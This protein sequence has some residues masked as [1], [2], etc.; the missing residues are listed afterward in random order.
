M[1]KCNIGLLS[2]TMA[3]ALFSTT[4]YATDIQVSVNETGSSCV[5][6]YLF[7]VEFEHAEKPGSPM[8]RIA[9]EAARF[10]KPNALRLDPSR[11]LES[12][13]ID[14]RDVTDKRKFMAY[15]KAIPEDHW[16]DFDL[17]TAET[18]QAEWFDETYPGNV[19]EI[20]KIRC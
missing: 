12:M 2:A 16:S 18:L 7:M 13:M 15:L 17:F 20:S 6:K 19:V 5:T 3:A 11:G 9:R 14:L 4:A 1:I 8:Y 10:A